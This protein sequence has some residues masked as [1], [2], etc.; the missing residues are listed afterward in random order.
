MTIKEAKVN[1]NWSVFW[2]MLGLV[3][4]FGSI[5]IRLVDDK[6]PN[7][8]NFWHCFSRDGRINFVVVQSIKAP[9]FLPVSGN[10]KVDYYCQKIEV[11]K[12]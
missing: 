7:L 4:I 9:S 2:V 3:A 10:E 11:K 6:A 5:N 12:L 1:V 8:D